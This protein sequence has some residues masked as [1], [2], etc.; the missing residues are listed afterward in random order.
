MSLLGIV[1]DKSKAKTRLDSPKGFVAGSTDEQLLKE[2]GAI[3]LEKGIWTPK[4]KGADVAE[5][6]NW[7]SEGKPKGPLPS[8]AKRL[9][10]LKREKLARGIKDAGTAD[11]A[12]TFEKQWIAEIDAI[13]S[14]SGERVECVV[15]F[16]KEKK[17]ECPPVPVPPASAA[18]ASDS[19]PSVAPASVPPPSVAPASVPPPSVEPA[20]VPP[21]SVEPAT[22][23][24]PSVEPATVPPPSVEPAPVPPPSVAPASVPAASGPK[25]NND[26]NNENLGSATAENKVEKSPFDILL[27]KLLEKYKSVDSATKPRL[28]RI[29]GALIT[30]RNAQNISDIVDAIN[31]I[32]AKEL[33]NDE[34]IKEINSIFGIIEKSINADETLGAVERL[35]HEATVAKK[36]FYPEIKHLVQELIYTTCGTASLL[37]PLVDHL[38]N[39]IATFQTINSNNSHFTSIKSTLEGLREML[40]KEALSLE[41]TQKSGVLKGKLEQ[42]KKDLDTLNTNDAS[43]TKIAPLRTQIQSLE[44]LIEASDN[45]EAVKE[46][47][48]SEL[49]IEKDLLLQLIGLLGDKYDDML[50]RVQGFLTNI[51]AELKVLSNASPNIKSITTECNKRAFEYRKF[52]EIL[53]TSES[54]EHKGIIAAL[55]AKNTDELRKQ[56]EE[57]DAIISRLQTQIDTDISAKDVRINAL[58]EELAAANAN[59]KRL[60]SSNA[61]KESQMQ[62]VS[63]AKNALNAELVTARAQIAALQEE[64]RIAEQ[65]SRNIKQRNDKIAAFERNTENL[66]TRGI[67]KD[68]FLKEERAG[69]TANAATHSAERNELTRQLDE[70]RAGRTANAAS[71]NARIAEL[72]GQL[73]SSKNLRSAIDSSAATERAA[74]ES[75]L[76]GLRNQIGAIGDERDKLSARLATAEAALAAQ[77]AA[78]NEASTT[79]SRNSERLTADVVR[80][81]NELAA[82]RRDGE[83]IDSL[84]DELQTARARHH[85]NATRISELQTEVE[86]IDDLERDLIAA[87]AS[88]AGLDAA[89]E[90]IAALEDELRLAANKRGENS[91]KLEEAAKVAPNTEAMRVLEER[92]LTAQQKVKELTEDLAKRDSDMFERLRIHGKTKANSVAKNE[93][94]ASLETEIAR[95]RSLKRGDSTTFGSSVRNRRAAFDTASRG[96]D[97]S[98]YAQS[99]RGP[100]TVLRSAGA[101][102]AHRERAAAGLALGTASRSAGVG[103]GTRKQKKKVARHTRKLKK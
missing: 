34:Q 6:L 70:E 1:I 21:P 57:K 63:A 55:E 38:H 31:N 5:F 93:K 73:K 97:P 41:T 87:R 64:L 86:R 74:L 25:V 79:A 45:I 22:V 82:A 16:I 2:I 39:L 76:A 68:R 98:K 3:V 47:K 28:E 75:N 17:A 60:E 91:A 102:E 12:R 42:L 81:T 11:Y 88:V 14:E 7:I 69:R 83:S 95:L 33:T 51:D 18:P 72:E 52:L 50:S 9:L 4:Y 32:M 80:L 99:H 78:A 35:V 48:R 54:E 24:P 62:E 13:F 59:I 10:C 8:L 92:L 40:I 84:T 37:D 66:V 30:K 46:M 67:E 103:G 71:R 27:E 100:G 19:P 89:K 36:T 23:P 43:S 61:E 94:I 49:N 20:P 29:L 15:D 58:T 101:E 90:R 53:K 56:A 65:T 96:T 77:R 85:S 26:N 44:A